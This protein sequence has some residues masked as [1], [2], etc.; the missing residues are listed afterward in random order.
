MEKNFNENFEKALSAVQAAES[1]KVDVA[2]RGTCQACLEQYVAKPY[3]KMKEKSRFTGEPM[4]YKPGSL[5][6]VKHGYERPGH[7]YLVGECWGVGH[8]P[9]QLDCAITKHWHR[10]LVTV[11][12][13]GKK[14]DLADLKSG[15]IKEFGFQVYLP[16]RPGEP[17]WKQRETKTIF[18]TEGKPIPPEWTNSYEPDFP[19]ARARAIK[20]VSGDIEEITRD[21]AHLAKAIAGWKYSPDALKPKEK[22][23]TEGQAIRKW[24]DGSTAELKKLKAPEGGPGRGSTFYDWMNTFPRTL[25]WVAMRSGARNPS[26]YKYVRETYEKMTGAKPLLAERASRAGE[27]IS[28]EKAEKQAAREAKVAAREA[29]VKAKTERADKGRGKAAEDIETF[30]KAFAE[31]LANDK[32]LAAFKT[33]KKYNPYTNESTMTKYDF[34]LD[35][36]KRYHFMEFIKG[37]QNFQDFVYG[38]NKDAYGD[39][40]MGKRRDMREIYGIVR[41]EAKEVGFKLKAL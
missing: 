25:A 15:K 39:A 24:M 5:V 16:R 1:G 34:V 11:Y 28:R 36:L 27:V 10:Y 31:I 23:L 14:K 2:A 21:I 13:P 26:Y 7:G 22:P 20:Q 38:K 19:S 37:E 12:L 3:T 33:A 6:M 29:A 30:R 9:F 41:D 17:T 35:L 4:N 32:L 8:P 40:V 18:L